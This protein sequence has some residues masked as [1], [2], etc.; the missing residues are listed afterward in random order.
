[1]LLIFVFCS[2]LKEVT[3]L[4]NELEGKLEDLNEQLEHAL[5][6]SD[7]TNNKL[8]QKNNDIHHE[9]LSRVIN[10]YYINFLSALFAFDLTNL[11]LKKTNSFL[12]QLL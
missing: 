5:K 1:M 4:K 9:K 7:H 10:Y 2:Q 6:V 8:M 12:R 3:S 11:F